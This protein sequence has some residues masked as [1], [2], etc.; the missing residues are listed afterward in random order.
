MDQIIEIDLFVKATLASFES[1][2]VFKTRVDWERFPHSLNAIHSTRST[3]SPPLYTLQHPSHYLQMAY[4]NDN[5]NS[6]SSPS[7]PE[8]LGPYPFLQPQASVTAGE[9][10]NGVAPTFTGGWTTVGQP[11]S[12]ADPSAGLLA[13]ASYGE[14]SSTLLIDLCLTSGSLGS[15]PSPIG[16]YPAQPHGSYWP[17]ITQPALPHHPGAWSPDDI[18]PGDQGWETAMQSLHI[19]PSKSHLSFENSRLQYSPA[20]N[21]SD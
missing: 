1:R 18:S 6:Y 9:V 3:A 12:M 13:G 19:N 8:E 17:T 4:F 2:E 20:A 7:T 21:S 11:E 15:V 16:L 14:H 5:C 10:Y